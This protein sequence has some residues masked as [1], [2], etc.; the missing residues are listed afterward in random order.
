MAVKKVFVCQSCG[1]EAPKWKGKCDGCQQWNTFMAEAVQAPQYE[2]DH[3]HLPVESLKGGDTES[4]FSRISTGFSEIDRVCGGG[5]VAG[6]V[7]LVAG[8]PGIGKSTLLLQLACKLS[9]TIPVLYVSGE[10]SAGQIRLRA[11]RLGLQDAEVHLISTNQLDGVFSVL[12]SLFVPS[13]NSFRGFMI[14]DS[15]QTMMLK[16]MGTTSGTLGQIRECMHHLITLAKSTGLAIM[17]VG[18]ITK[19]G[20]I[21][22]PKLLEHMVDTVLYF[23]GDSNRPHRVLRTIKNRFGATHEVGV[24][25][26]T[27]QGLKEVGN[28]SAFFLSHR[29]HGLAGS[30]IFPAIEGS[31]PLLVEFQALV[32]PS[33]LASPRR[34]VVGSDYNRLSM[35][36]AILEARCAIPFSKKDVFLTVLGGLKIVEPAA[37]LCVALALVS[38]MR[39]QAIPR[40]AIAFGEMGLTGEMYASSHSEHRLREAAL[41]GFEQAFFPGI[42]GSIPFLHTLNHCPMNHVKDLMTWF[43]SP[44][45]PPSS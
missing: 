40:G 25:D 23:E 34:S 2:K 20:T 18:H 4:F 12:P 44:S 41:L 42:Q 19:E 11:K 16:E 39:K 24:F 30:C 22:G 27:E 32:A 31:R 13:S 1:L 9:K 33:F 28:P 21:A 43:R 35:I 3:A 37:D 6:S 7:T 14:V 8:D 36:L 10:E 29:H 17:V 26:M 5:L 45:I 38:C 15:I